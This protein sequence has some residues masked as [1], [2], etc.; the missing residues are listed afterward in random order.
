MLNVVIDYRNKPLIFP[1]RFPPGVYSAGPNASIEY[2]QAAVL[3][4]RLFHTSKEILLWRIL[5]YVPIY[6]VMT[7]FSFKKV[8]LYRSV[9]PYLLAIPTFASERYSQKNIKSNQLLV[10]VRLR[11]QIKY[12]INLCFNLFWSIKAGFQ[13]AAVQTPMKSHPSPSLIWFYITKPAYV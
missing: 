5:V 4:T 10:N 2:R 3:H 8:S 13:N 11:Q 1:I 9:L 7:K 6:T 12:Y